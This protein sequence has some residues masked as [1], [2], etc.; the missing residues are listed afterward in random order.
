MENYTK[1]KRKRKRRPYISRLNNLYRVARAFVQQSRLSRTLLKQLPTTLRGFNY[2]QEW[3][4]SSFHHASPPSKGSSASSWPSNPLKSYFDLHKEGRGIWKWIHYFDIYHHH[5]KKFVGREVHMLEVG[6]Y[7][8]GSLEMWRDYFG[9][10][11]HIYGVDT[12]KDCKVYENEYTSV[13]IGDQADRKF[14][15]QF[16]S[17]VPIIDILIDDGGHKAEQQIVT[18]EE[19]L[20]RLS[21]GGVYICEDIHRS[22]NDFTSY[23]SGLIK[24]LNN[25]AWGLEA[26]TITPIPFQSWIQSIHFYPHVV[27]IEKA[28]KPVEKFISQKHGDQW[29]PS[30]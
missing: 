19:M 15:A 24:S 29:R 23:V 16:K 20:P 26:N 30:W 9:T 7:S 28:E 13:F 3:R 8:G 11:C 18:L 5:L 21:P 1:S 25:M 12:E 4:P 22:D 17:K 2:S 27:V 14:W 10:K 6:I